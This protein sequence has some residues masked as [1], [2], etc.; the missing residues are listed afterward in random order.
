[1]I[2]AIC[3][4]VVIAWAIAC[5]RGTDGQ[6]ARFLDEPALW[7]N[8]ARLA[9]GKPRPWVNLG[10]AYVTRGDTPAA[11]LAFRNAIELSRN[12]RLTVVER[13]QA[14]TLSSL[15]LALLRLNADDVDGA[16]DIMV[17][18]EQG[19]TDPINAVEEGGL[20]QWLRAEAAHRSRSSSSQ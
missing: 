17:A 18:A 19:P 14:R 15:N 3:T 10:V 11:E 8:A 12:P 2:R 13:Y 6:V 1:M 9:P 4:V 16:V 5:V 7:R 20:T